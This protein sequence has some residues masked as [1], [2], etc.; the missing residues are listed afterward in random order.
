MTNAYCQGFNSLVDL[1]NSK[2]SMSKLQKI[3]YWYK[4]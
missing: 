4:R 3:N 2:T 1:N